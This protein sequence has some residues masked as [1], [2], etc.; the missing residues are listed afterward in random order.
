MSNAGLLKPAGSFYFFVSE[1]PT[2]A[3]KEEAIGFVYLSD[4]MHFEA[5]RCDGFDVPK[6]ITGIST[7]PIALNIICIESISPYL[8]SRVVCVAC[9]RQFLRVS[10][11]IGFD[12]SIPNRKSTRTVRVTDKL[13]RLCSGMIGIEM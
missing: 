10:F 13:Q 6:I 8:L 9:V 3:G 7:D 2:Y 11:S 1:V 5:L 4:H 12:L